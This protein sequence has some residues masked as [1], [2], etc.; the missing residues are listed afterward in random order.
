MSC[1]P[2]DSVA[3]RIESM[4]MGSRQES[5]TS[6]E[7]IGQAPDGWL[8]VEDLLAIADVA[9]ALNEF[10][11]LQDTLSLICRRISVLLGSDFSAIRLP[12]AKAETLA[13]A[14]SDRLPRQIDPLPLS[15][16]TTSPTVAAYHSGRVRII[17]DIERH[18]ALEPWRESAHHHG[19]RGMVSV[20]II[21]QSRVIGILN[22]YW[23]NPYSPDPTQMHLLE[24]MA[25]LSGIAIE[26]ARLGEQQGA[27]LKELEAS[28]DQ[29]ATQNDQLTRILAAHGRM[30]E[31][32]EYEGLAFLEAIA[33]AL[34]EALGRSI[35]ILDRS[36]SVLATA[37][38]PGA[39][40]LAI[41]RVRRADVRARLPFAARLDLEDAT[42]VRVGDAATH[43]ASVIVCPGFT[44]DETI[45]FL[46][47]THAAAMVAAHL[48]REDADRE[49]SWHTRP[50]VL[51]ALIRGTTHP[52][53]VREAGG[54][55]GIRSN[56]V[57]RLMVMTC[58]T[59]EA[60]LR[61]SRRVNTTGTA[62]HGFVTATSDGADAVA[63]FGADTRLERA[64][65]ELR[66]ANPEMESIGVSAPLTLHAM[67]RAFRQAR[68]ASRIASHTA[69]PLVRF[70]DL[71]DHA[72]LFGALPADT[73][74]EIIDRNLGPLLTYDRS[75]GTD[76]VLTVE[77]FLRSDANVDRCAAR[78]NIH[79]NTV[80]QRLQR[81]AS[82][83]G[84]DLHSLHGLSE[85]VLA[86]ECWR[87]RE[88]PGAP[89]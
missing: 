89:L 39:T 26:T 41:A 21:Q 40:D 45:G 80:R 87:L 1:L 33:S 23:S 19:F 49:R 43:L 59:A 55:L 79:A 38:S 44:R 34:S 56:A 48:H 32:L 71:G 25:R 75:R 29:L 78:L 82:I 64:L 54:L 17:D 81:A 73:I 4:W 28:R 8:A 68:A 52:V 57:L 6:A 72:D 10:R 24:L 14:G 5:S 62:Q 42:C 22:C 85:M 12:D 63:L 77:A 61:V 86:V 9:H 13:V 58:T 65:P 27:T 46:L 47:T 30:L 11:P 3:P 84:I 16:A 50:S 60:A 76:L 36:G 15:D 37:G 74:S 2:H 66:R 18:A 83:T 53:E 20:P 31:S 35:A 88:G 69:A 67:D 7:G 51:L 70:D